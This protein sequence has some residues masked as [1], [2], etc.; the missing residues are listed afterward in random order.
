MTRRFAAIVVSALMLCAPVAADVPF[1]VKGELSGIARVVDGDGLL[2]GGVEVRLQGIAAPEDNAH[3]VERGGPEATRALRR[4]AE[5]R[6]ASCYLDGSKTR[7][8]PVGVCLVDGEDVG[9]V[10]V[11]EGFARDCPRYSKGRYSNAEKAAVR[12]G[13]KLATI[14]PLPRYC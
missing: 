12:S 14:Y 8:R 9:A 6:T 7:G 5:G 13:R 4:L 1:P 10:M 3:K 2:I 11:Q